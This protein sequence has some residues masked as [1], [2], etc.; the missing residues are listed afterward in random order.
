MDELLILLIP[1]VILCIVSGPIALVLSILALSKISQRSYEA[2]RQ[3]MVP[4]L[5]SSPPIEHPVTSLVDQVTTVREQLVPPLPKVIQPAPRIE[6]PSAPAEFLQS[7]DEISSETPTP[8]TAGFITKE[9]ETKADTES[10]PQTQAEVSRP[11]LEQV[12]GT[13]WV[14]IAGV[15]SV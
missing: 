1:L 14:M 13:R 8:S 11:S 9:P 10:Q 4:P 5:I 12:I 6:T 3:T 7:S 15:V 2:P